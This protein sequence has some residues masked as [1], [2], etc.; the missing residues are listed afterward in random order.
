LHA[1]RDNSKVYVSNQA[2]SIFK[3]D[4]ATMT[5][6]KKIQLPAGI[7]TIVSD[8]HWVYAGCDNGCVY[9]CSTD[10]PRVA[11]RLPTPAVESLLPPIDQDAMNLDLPAQEQE[12]E[13]PVTADDA[14][15]VLVN[16]ARQFAFVLDISGSMEDKI[17]AANKNLRM[18]LDSHLNPEDQLS[19]FRFSTTIQKIFEGFTK[20]DNYTAI[21]NAFS[22]NRV[23]ASTAFWDALDEGL[24]S[25]IKA[26]Q[27][28]ANSEKWLIALTDGSDNSSKKQ[29]AFL[30]PKFAAAGVNVVVIGVGSLD[31]QNSIRQICK[32]SPKGRY[33]SVGQ[34][35]EAGLDEAFKEIAE[36]ISAKI[37]WL[38]VR[39]GILAVSG[40]NGH[41]ALCN[42]EGEKMWENTQAPGK[43]EE[44]QDQNVLAGGWM[45][46]SDF[47]GV[48]QGVGSSVFKFD[49]GD[50]STLWETK[51]ENTDGKNVLF[52]WQSE[53]HVFVAAGKKVFKLNKG[54]G[55]VEAIF[56]CDQ[57]VVST[58]LSLDGKQLFAADCHSKLYGFENPQPQVP[59][60]ANQP[61]ANPPRIWKFATGCGTAL[62]MQA[63]KDDKLYIATTT[64]TLACIDVSD[65]AMKNALTGHPPARP[66]KVI[67]LDANVETILPAADMEITQDDSKGVILE[68]CYEF[69]DEELQRMNQ[70]IFD[71]ACKEVD[72]YGNGEKIYEIK[73][74]ATHCRYIRIGSTTI[75][76]QNK[77]K[78][79]KYAEMA[80]K[81]QQLLWLIHEGHHWG[82]LV[83]GKIIKP[84][85]LRI[86][87]IKETGLNPNWNV[88][89]PKCKRQLGM[90]Y[91][92]DELLPA[93]QGEYYRIN[94][95]IKVLQKVT[96]N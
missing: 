13:Q 25:L 19:F 74:N 11:Y 6:E 54:N 49:V 4:V 81:G 83:D 1:S 75:M 7:K 89:V 85:K 65:A 59:L 57:I 53:H 42:I 31:N 94:G 44:N 37:T 76:E 32:A 8:F 9:E 93:Q 38:D 61:P 82:L 30:L 29:P 21:Q 27:P 14:N 63:Q 35:D 12:Q 46:R 39:D 67:N 95:D 18:I 17:R 24:E 10:V 26:A 58:S 45:V 50:G 33:I 86:R 36:M 48:Y 92:A 2:G 15:E 22:N 71:P 78:D 62:S 20:K 80:R 56:D 77:A 47:Q 5:V 60:P 64:G 23:D 16:K 3:V 70:A 41:L 87:P 66:S 51:L 28:D 90:R 91:V 34:S 72:L 69:T 55:V 68:C 40:M 88:Q 79:S 52:G 96:L 43:P 73:E 84:L